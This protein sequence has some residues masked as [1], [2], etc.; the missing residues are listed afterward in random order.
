LQAETGAFCRAKI[1][2][3][4]GMGPNKKTLTTEQA[5]QRLRHYCG[6]Q[7]RCHSE[8][9]EKLYRLGVFKNEQDAIIATLIEEGYLNEERFAITFAG[10][11]FRVKQWGRVKIKYELKQKQVSEYSIKKALQQIE[12]NEYRDVLKKLA[13]EKYASLKNEQPLVKKKKTIDYLLQRGFEM[14]LVRSVMGEE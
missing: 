6:Y 9:K 3:K 11:K 12:E 7:E 1:N 2:K 13:D 8:V 4:E 14:E 5:L 10:G